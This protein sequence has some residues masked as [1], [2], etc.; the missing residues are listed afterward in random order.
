[1][2]SIQTLVKLHEACGERFDQLVKEGA[3]EGVA[4]DRVYDCYDA[5]FIPGKHCYDKRDR[6]FE[7]RL[8]DIARENGE[9]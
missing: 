9:S 5:L 7:T 3:A 1:M 2:F 8:R 4:M 6:L